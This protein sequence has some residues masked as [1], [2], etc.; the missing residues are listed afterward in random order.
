MLTSVPHN[1]GEDILGGRKLLLNVQRLKGS[2]CQQIICADIK[3]S[4]DIQQKSNG[5]PIVPV[6][7]F[8][9]SLQPSSP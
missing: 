1:A 7:E 8:P 6:L 4:V 3:E 9:L 2:A 5:A